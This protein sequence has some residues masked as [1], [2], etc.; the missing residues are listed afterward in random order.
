MYTKTIEFTDYNGVER[1]EKYYFNLSKAEI[2]EKELG[3]EESYSDML[4]RIVVA[5]DQP[6]IFAAFKSLILDSYGEKSIDGKHF[7]KI[8]NDG[9]RLAN[10]FAQT[11]AFSELF[12]LLGTDT[13]EAVKFVNGIMPFDKN[14]SIEDTTDIIRKLKEDDSD[15]SEE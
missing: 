3:S 2:T 8:A 6:A 13:D 4:A 11:E 7:M 5:E 1:K 10:D 9:H 14:I 15:S 12:M